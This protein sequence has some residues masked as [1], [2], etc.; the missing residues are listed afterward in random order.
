[1]S[2]HFSVFE[3]N[4]FINSP[5]P[6]IMETY[7]SQFGGFQPSQ[8]GRS[9]W[10]GFTLNQV[11]GRG[12]VP[13]PPLAYICLLFGHCISQ[14]STGETGPLMY[15]EINCKQSVIKLTRQV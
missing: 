7:L 2:L 3:L 1:M 5:F 11:L 15:I 6:L 14:G 8:D 13:P 4:F 9:H 10:R 12:V